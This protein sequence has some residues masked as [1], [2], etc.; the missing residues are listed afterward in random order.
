MT[1]KEF[2]IT[3]EGREETIQLED[4]DTAKA[5]VIMPIVK[6]VLKY[7][8]GQNMPE[9]DAEEWLIGIA[10]NCI[11]KAPWTL[12]N[13]DV[14]RNLGIK[15]YEQLNYIIGDEYPIERFLSLGLKLMY[16]RKLEISVSTSPTESITSSP[17]GESP[18]KE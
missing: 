3:Y 11:Y 7:K 18:R 4:A 1:T 6:R 8:V 9:M 15:E 12:K 2:K 17:S 13:P 5:G 16:G 10:T 14:V